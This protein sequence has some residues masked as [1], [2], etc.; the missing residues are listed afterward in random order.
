MAHVMRNS[1]AGTAVSFKRGN[2]TCLALRFAKRPQFQKDFTAS[3]VG[4][5]AS[6]DGERVGHLA[7]Q[8]LGAGCGLVLALCHAGCDQRTDKTLRIAGQADGRSEFHECL[9]EIAWVGRVN[10]LRG[11]VFNFALQCGFSAAAGKIQPSN[12]HKTRSTFPSTTATA[13]SCAML[14]MA[15]AV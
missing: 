8:H 11:Q 10:E 1:S 3:L 2:S 14:A 7:A 6:A 5:A 13:S 4:V 15:A 9:V 12:R